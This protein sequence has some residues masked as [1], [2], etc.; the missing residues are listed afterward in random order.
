MQ[1]DVGNEWDCGIFENPQKVPAQIWSFAVTRSCLCQ[2]STATQSMFH[3][4]NLLKI[5]EL[6]SLKLVAPALP[7]DKATEFNDL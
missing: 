3:V 2:C 5:R 4:E 1:G 6:D 7:L